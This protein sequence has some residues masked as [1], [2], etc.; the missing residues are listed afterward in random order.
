M[1]TRNFLIVYTGSMIEPHNIRTRYASRKCAQNAADRM[2]ARLDA[3]KSSGSRYAVY[4]QDE[5][6]AEIDGKGEWKVS[7]FTGRKV[8]VAL[9][10]PACCDPTTE[11]YMSM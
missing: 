8:W 10:T 7:P 11:T 2:N 9:G 6:N 1:K 3:R 4:S 5:Y